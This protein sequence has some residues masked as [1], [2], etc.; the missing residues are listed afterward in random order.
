MP[1]ATWK[2]EPAIVEHT[3][4]LRYGAELHEQLEHQPKALLNRY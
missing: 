1:V 4:D 3:H 2:V